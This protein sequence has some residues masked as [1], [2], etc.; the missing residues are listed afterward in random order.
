MMLTPFFMLAILFLSVGLSV[1]L[2]SA[3]PFWIAASVFIGYIVISTWR[4]RYAKRRP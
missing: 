4:S 2:L 3:W 1:L